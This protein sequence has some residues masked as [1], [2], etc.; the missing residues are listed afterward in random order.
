MPVKG[1]RMADGCFVRSAK[2]QHIHDY[3][4]SWLV[5]HW[6]DVRYSDLDIRLR[7]ANGETDRQSTVDFV[8]G[9]LIVIP[10]LGPT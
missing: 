7:K 5:P 2:E 3:L 8:V 4:V 10:R 9:Q 6:C 1:Y